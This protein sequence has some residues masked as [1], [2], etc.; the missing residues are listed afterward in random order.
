[1]S[2]EEIRTA[3]R[4]LIRGAGVR[5]GS[6][7]LHLDEADLSASFVDLLNEEGFL[8]SRVEDIDIEPG[9]KVP[10]FFI[11]G[12]MAHFGWVFWEVFFPGRMRKIFGSVA[13]NE[14]GDWAIVIG[15][16]KQER[17]YVNGGMRSQMDVDR[18]TEF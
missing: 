8:P 13:R 3:L 10:A 15:K 11:S 14:K 12:D 17:V 16:G 1:M 6:H 5:R 7:S 4:N 18:P 9:E 2:T